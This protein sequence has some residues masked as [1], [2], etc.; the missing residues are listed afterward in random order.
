[1]KHKRYCF[2]GHATIYFLLPFTTGGS[3]LYVAGSLISGGAGGLT[4]DFSGR[5][6]SNNHVLTFNRRQI[7]IK[8]KIR[9]H[10]MSGKTKYKINKRKRRD[11]TSNILSSFYFQRIYC[12][13]DVVA[14]YTFTS[15]LYFSVDVGSKKECG[16]KDGQK[17]KLLSYKI[18]QRCLK[19]H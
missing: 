9:R 19:V 17:L 4:T 1:M 3:Q 18:L 15:C 6:V 5:V 14:R 16:I 11:F 12:S 7:I 2:H 13:R 8:R 10:L